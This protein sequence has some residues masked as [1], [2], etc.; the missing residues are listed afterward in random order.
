MK[1]VALGVVLAAAALAGLAPAVAGTST[2]PGTYQRQIFTATNDQ[3]RAHD[4]DPLRHQAC[5]QRFAERQAKRMALQ[6]RLFH[7]D[8]GRV[9]DD[10][11]LHSAGENVAFGFDTGRSV[12]VDGW[13]ES[14]PHRANILHSSYRLLGSGARLGDDGFW[15]AVQVF[16]RG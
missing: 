13:M 4:L 2:S 12:V 9:L 8:L 7:Q 10:C 11:D 3:R 5:V 15:Y 14:P 6:E 16:G 1:V